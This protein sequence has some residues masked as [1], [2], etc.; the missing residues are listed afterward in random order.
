[1]RRGARW[2]LGIGAGAGRD[3][4][5][6]ARAR[7][8]VPSIWT[9]APEAALPPQSMI[10]LPMRTTRR[11]SVTLSLFGGG[12]T[13][14]PNDAQ[15]RSDLRPEGH[16]AGPG[17]TD[18]RPRSRP[19]A[20]RPRRVPASRLTTFSR[21]SSTFRSPPTRG[22]SRRPPLSL[23]PLARQPEPLTDVLWAGQALFEP[24][25]SGE[26][27]VSPCPSPLTA[28]GA[29]D[30]GARPAPSLSQTSEPPSVP[31]FGTSGV[32]C[33]H[34]SLRSLEATVGRSLPIARYDIQEST[35]SGSPPASLRRRCNL[36]RAALS[37]T[38]PSQ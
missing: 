31:Q 27:P 36:R 18:C 10:R 19:S 33:G 4:G 9:S 6:A 21:T 34:N 5:G 11:P 17:R 14:D 29:A 38:N 20:R 37:H 7:T 12:G 8:S 1:M 3:S 23:H 16:A 22:R 32:V 15:F 30:G 25:S 28:A 26:P 13:D 35:L 24:P 2:A